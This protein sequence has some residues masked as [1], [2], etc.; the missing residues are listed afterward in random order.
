MRHTTFSRNA[1]QPDGKILESH[2]PYV[3]S[4]LNPSTPHGCKHE[5]VVYT[6]FTSPLAF[7]KCHSEGPPMPT[8]NT[9]RVPD[10]FRNVLGQT[11]ISPAQTLLLS[12]HV[13]KVMIS[14][15]ICYPD[16]PLLVN[17]FSHL[18]HFTLFFSSLLRKHIQFILGWVEIYMAPIH[19]RPIVAWQHGP[20]VISTD[21]RL[22]RRHS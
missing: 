20:S 3:N 1:N 15:E 13:Y 19:Y 7:W 14:D 8:A 6:N 12:K 4:Y 10:A 2:V 11:L 22:Y 18:R 21:V 5:L 16:F 17:M 9:P